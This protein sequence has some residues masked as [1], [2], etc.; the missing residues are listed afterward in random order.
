MRRW[1]GLTLTAGMTLMLAGCGYHTSGHAVQLPADLHSIAVP[2]FVNRTQT[3]RIEQLLTEAVVREFNTR[4][5]YRVV[6]GGDAD[7]T[8][9]GTVT[10]TSVSPVT[11]DS[12]T[13]RT[14][15]ALVT[16]TINVALV[17]KKGK[18]L[19][20]QSG[21]TF[22]EEY[23]VSREISSFF[24]E[25]SPALDRLSRSFARALVSNVLEAF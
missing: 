23:Q 2:A 16:V 13:G 10:Y 22:R 7:S 12:T 8:L 20:R 15:T 9:H 3:Y 4:S 21:Y 6:P 1:I 5:N 14:S 18:V 11:Y 24:Q 25:E 19:F 17:D